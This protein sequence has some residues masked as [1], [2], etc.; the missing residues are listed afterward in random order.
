MFMTRKSIGPYLDM[1]PITKATVAVIQF[2]LWVN[3]VRNS[4][5]FNFL[6]KAALR[7]KGRLT[8][9]TTLTPT[10]ETRD[11]AEEP[12][13]AP[14]TR[15]AAVPEPDP[16][17]QSAS[18][19]NHSDWVGVLVKEIR[20]MSQML[21]ECISPAIEKPSLCLQEGQPNSTAVEPT[22][23]TTVQGPA[24][25]QRQ[26]Q[27]A[28]V[29]PVE[30]RRS[31]MKAEHPDKDRNG[32]TSQP[33]GEPEVA[34]ITE[35]LRYESLR[36]LHKD[37]VR[38]GREAYTT[39]LLRVWD[40]MGTGVQLDG[41]EA[42][43]LG[44]LTQDSGMNQ[45]FV[46]EPGSLSLW[47]RLLMSVRERFVHR[48][49]MQEHHHRMRW[50]TLE[51]GIQQLRE[52]AILEVLFGRDGQHDNDPDKVR[53]TGQMLWSLAN[54]GPSQYTTFIATID[55]DTNRETVGSVANKLRNY[56]SMINGPMQAHISAVIKEFKEE[57]REMREEM[58]KVNAAPVRVT[59]PKFSA[60][61]SPAR[62]RGYTPR[63]NLWFFLRDHGEDMGRWDGKPTSVLA[64]RVRQLKEGNSNR[65]TSTKVKVAS[66][67]HDRAAGQGEA[68]ENRIF[69]TVW[70]RWPGTSEPQK[71][72][73]LVDTGAQCT[74]IPSG[75]V[76]AEAVS[77]AG[78]TGGSQQLTLVEAEVS[79]TGK[80][81]KKHSIVTGPDAPCILGI[82]FLR[83]GYYK[84]PKGLRWAFG[85]AAVEAENIKQLN[86]LPGLSENPSA[87][88]LLRV[89][90]QRVPIA[91]S[92]VHRRQYRTDRDA[93]IPIH[94]MIR[95]LESQG[96]VSKTHSPFNSPIWPVRKSDRE[97]RLTVD[98]RGLNEVTPPLSA[99]VPDM[100]ELQYE[101]ESKAAKWY[102]TIDIANAF[103]SI[104][105]AAECRPQFAFTWRG[106]QY[107]W[108]R[109]PQGWKHSPT[110][111][112]GLIQTAL[113]KGEAPEH[114][115]YIDDI[116]VWGSTVAEVFE[117]GEKII[118]ILLKAGFAIKKSKVKGPAR[119]IQF[120]GVKWQ[121]GRRQIPTEVINKITAMSPPTSKKETQAFLGAIG[122]WRMHIPEYSQIVSPLYL[123]T[124]KKNDFHWGPEQQQA[125]TQ[126][127]QEIAHA[128]ALGPVRTGPEV[129]NVLYSAAGNNGLSWSLWQKV[130]GETRGRPLGFWSRGYRGSEANYTP[131][132]KEI[133]AAY[134]GVQAASEV[135]GTEAQLLLAPRLP[136]LGWMFKG[137]VPTTH[138][139]TDATWSKWIALITQRARI[140]NPNRPGILEIIT[141]WPE[142]ENFG[143]T[144]DEEQEQATR[145]EE[146]PP[147]NQLPAEETC[148][149]LFTDG[150]CRIVGMNR[151]WKAAVWS[152]TRQV[153]QATEGEGGSSQ[154]AE[155]KAVQLA[156][157]IAEREKWPRLYLYTDSWMVANALWGWLGRWRKANWQRRGKPI[158]AADIWKDIASRVEKLT[159]K[160]R[161]VDA[162]VPKGRANEEHRN[163]EQVDQAARIEVSKIDLDWHHKGELFLARWAHDASGHQGRDATYKWAR[164]RG[165]D[166]TMDSI[167]QVIHD[168]ETCAAIKQ[169]KRV[170][171]LWYGGRWSKY[172][173]GEAW[174]I[175][176]I[177]LP[178]TRQGKRYV[179]TMVEATTGW[180]ETYPVPHATARNTILG[181]EKQVLWR[182]GTPERIESDNGTH[183]KNGLINTWAR[184]HGIEWI[185][186]I[187][188]HAPAAGKVERCNGLLKTTLKAL[189]GGT[190]RN[191]E[192]NLAKAT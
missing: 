41:G 167:S 143:L 13:T 45:I 81:W 14:E 113:E 49:R 4:W 26:S 91:T 84:D 101:L 138:H 126:I 135:I 174:Q 88:G 17:P 40:L 104:P 115:Q 149:A 3:K 98:Y 153:A 68:R 94:R 29:A 173:Y 78:V 42:R 131:T 16:A 124:R 177:T 150:S 179:L 161:H 121:D 43:N 30:T 142:G 106:V 154:L 118:Q 166:L 148:Y 127:K 164:D 111:C 110:I 73:A 64:A 190:F 109:L 54:L 93:V 51:E 186:H 116:I 140:G 97:W 175:D 178:Q 21:K 65:G 183:F 134:E 89:E 123:V 125:F 86:T 114:L 60:Q 102:A 105:L 79:L 192:M 80:E 31:K 71:Y 46:R 33:T 15:D 39:W 158:W 95:E 24:E 20:E 119:E 44:P 2:G 59:G 61:H 75:Q 99:A 176:Y 139:A 82:D 57:M 133:L 172:K 10:P 12:D 100:L 187:P 96:V 25:P 185:Y 165:V 145:A 130:P 76:G 156:L 157:D 151:K 8:W 34:I 56:E 184:E 7:D 170:K 144:D 162:H 70:I 11:A 32:G 28:A 146:A 171:P 74:L 38:R 9:R 120:L 37:I 69:W 132:E 155:L 22:G 141:N 47:E 182:H 6:W 108:N 62:D 50:K 188:Y 103:F 168:C 83:N 147:Y 189:G 5:I 55:A 90:E 87:V 27:P 67:S 191:W 159:V 58:K 152:P 128:V 117:K 23:V 163:N 19:M 63:A 35:S 122:F 112:H 137:K 180:L 53:C 160:V 77:I 1:G 66:T 129:K 92:T 18:E 48:E 36:N 107:T 136:V 85:I 181:L 52:V 169:A 72:D